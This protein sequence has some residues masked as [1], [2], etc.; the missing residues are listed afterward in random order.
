VKA[1]YIPMSI[2]LSNGAEWVES[3]AQKAK[4]ANVNAFVFTVKDEMGRVWIYNQELV[5]RDQQVY[6]T[7]R[8]NLK[9]EEYKRV[10]DNV[11]DWTKIMPILEKYNIKPIAR[12]YCFRD[13]ATAYF[14]LMDHGIMK[15]GTT[16]KWFDNNNRRWLSPYS[17]V[18]KD[19]IKQVAQIAIDAG[20]KEI[21]LY[22]ALFPYEGSVNTTGHKFED[23]RTKEQVI[24]EFIDNMGEFCKKKDVD[25]SVYVSV[26]AILNKMPAASGANIDYAKLNVDIVSLN[27]TGSAMNDVIKV[28]DAKKIRIY[29]NYSENV[30]NDL[31]NSNDGI[32]TFVVSDGEMAVD[33][34]KIKLP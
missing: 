34:D 24:T 7:Y 2:L 17:S 31:K 15:S 30:S 10:L 18:A 5:D 16:Q 12:L 21:E 13:N 32:K 1:V 28:V 19:Y 3:Y 27:G 20:F 4:E 22:D 14:A 8:A 26:D 11:P 29:A 9:L 23:N 6:N 33:M 25:L